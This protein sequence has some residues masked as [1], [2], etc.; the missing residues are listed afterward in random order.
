MIG[1]F[2]SIE[3]VIKSNNNIFKGIDEIEYS[4]LMKTIYID[5]NYSW[6]LSKYNERILFHM[7][8]NLILKN[9]FS[10]TIKFICE[11][12]DEVKNCKRFEIT[13]IKK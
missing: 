6:K 9:N 12:V 2:K 5:F 13:E 11:D 7:I 8:T 1:L 3:N 4:D 10:C